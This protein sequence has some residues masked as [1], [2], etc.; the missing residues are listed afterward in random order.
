MLYSTIFTI[1]I[2][3]QINSVISSLTAFIDL[4]ETSSY[5]SENTLL[6][7]SPSLMGGVKTA[8]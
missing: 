5:I 6:L 7:A 1:L 8:S 4:S 2:T 3:T